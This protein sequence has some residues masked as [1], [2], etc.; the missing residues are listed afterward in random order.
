LR[1]SKGGGSKEAQKFHLGVG[2]VRQNKGGGQLR[3][4]HRKPKKKNAK[5]GP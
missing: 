1:A 2:K 3:N 5:V 4:K